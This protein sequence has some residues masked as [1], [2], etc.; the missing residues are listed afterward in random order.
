MERL[1]SFCYTWKHENPRIPPTTGEAAP[2]GSSASEK[3]EK[4]VGCCAPDARV[5]K[6]SL[7]MAPSLSEGRL[8]WLASQ[9][10]TGATTEAVQEAEE[11]IGKPTPPRL[12]EL[13]LSNRSVDSK[14]K[15]TL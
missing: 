1:H 10:H 11:E 4:S 3:V 8:E 6:F 5:Q 2:T 12:S 15:G 14:D 7:P 9:I 13:R